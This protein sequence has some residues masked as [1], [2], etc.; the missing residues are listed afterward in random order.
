MA[1]SLTAIWTSLRER[2]AALAGVRQGLA[3]ALSKR[4]AG[5]EGAALGVH[6]LGQTAFM[7]RRS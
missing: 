3:H 7:V 6:D 1:M 2:T 5:E 4:P